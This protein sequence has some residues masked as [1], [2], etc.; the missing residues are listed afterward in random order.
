M[1]RLVWLG[2]VLTA[3]FV[4]AQISNMAQGS[5][6]H[7]GAKGEIRKLS[8]MKLATGPVECGDYFRFSGV[9]QDTTKVGMV[10]FIFESTTNGARNI[11]MPSFGTDK[12][13]VRIVNGLKAPM[14]TVLRAG[15]PVYPWVEISISPQDLKRAPCLQY[16]NSVV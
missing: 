6:M 2:L 3:I 10:T 11:N 12:L 14:A 5:A 16:V 13:R 15:G 9:P 1:K 8:E 4:I 7:P